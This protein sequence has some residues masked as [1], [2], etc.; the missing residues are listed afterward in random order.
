MYYKGGK[1]MIL[2]ICSIVMLICGLL[3]LLLPK[4]YLVNEKNI[5]PGETEDQAVKRYRILAIIF[6]VLG[7]IFLFL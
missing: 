2:T 6:I 1:K 7:L 3:C 5:K 4:K